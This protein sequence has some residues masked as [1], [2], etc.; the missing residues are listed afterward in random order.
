MIREK[1]LAAYETMAERYNELIDHKP[2]NA[3]YDRPNTLSLLPEVNGKSV[4]DAA[5]G[6]G[7]YAEILLSRGAE[8]TG[9]DLSPRM[10]ELAKERNAGTAGRFYVHDLTRPLDKCVDGSFDVVL[11]A[12]AMHYIEDWTATIREFYRVLKPSGQ[13]ILSIEHPFFE[14]LYF[15]S[16]TYFATEAVRCTWSGFG[17]PIEVNS[18][19]RPLSACIG[20]LTENGFYLDKLLEPKPVP[21]F[22]KLDPKHFKELNEFPAFMCLRAIRRD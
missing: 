20:P 14:Y 17:K 3:Y 15:K 13:L 12:L 18:Y 7:K 19:R 11:C 1:I 16:E 6:P 2:H 10:V 21:E 5:C 22:E 4:L 8:V 9:F